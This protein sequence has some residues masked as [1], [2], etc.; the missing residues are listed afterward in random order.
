MIRAS[1]ETQLKYL[2]THNS[3]EK[4]YHH[5]K[6]DKRNKKRQF[7][8]DDNPHKT[9]AHMCEDG[10]FRRKFNSEKKCPPLGLLNMYL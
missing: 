1:I 3:N 5:K 2:V 7:L 9:R 6:I 8:Y 10:H 4:Y